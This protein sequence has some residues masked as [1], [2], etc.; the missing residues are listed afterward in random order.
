[1][2]ADLSYDEAIQR[3]WRSRPE[4][5]FSYGKF[6]LEEIEYILQSAFRPQT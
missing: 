5:G 2:A 6:N 3:I 1:M 4:C